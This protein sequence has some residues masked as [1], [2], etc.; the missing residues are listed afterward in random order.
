M[1]DRPIFVDTNILIYAYSSQEEAK[2]ET[3]M[4]LLVCGESITSAQVLNEFSNVM[5]KKFPS[6]YENV[7]ASL[8]EIEG[9]MPILPLTATMT[10]RAVA[11]SKRY[12]LSFYDSLI[13]TAASETQCS[14]VVSEDLQDGFVMEGVTVLNPFRDEGQAEVL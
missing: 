14:V 8:R 3:A 9:H 7:E 12:M 11:I 13:L 5:R 4:R 10:H 2:R 6:V 1:S